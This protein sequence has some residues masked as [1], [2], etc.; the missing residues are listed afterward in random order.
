LTSLSA[1]AASYTSCDSVLRTAS[2]ELWS[3]SD[4]F[5][6]NWSCSVFLSICSFEYVRLKCSS[7]SYR[8]IPLSSRNITL[9]SFRPSSSINISDCISVEVSFDFLDSPLDLTLLSGG[10][11]FK[12]A[13]MLWRSWNFN[14]VGYLTY[15]SLSW[16]SFQFWA[17]I[18][19]SGKM[20]STF[21][22]IPVN[23]RPCISLIGSRYSC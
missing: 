6:C 12:E 10:S 14:S 18:D 3:Q 20:L 23:W 15:S 11:R 8:V 7:W 19:H 17:A 2:S 21:A 9:G 13:R 16:L 1:T 4:M 22:I 5:W